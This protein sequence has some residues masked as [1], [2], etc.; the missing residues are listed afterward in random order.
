MSFWRQI[1]YWLTMA[2]A[3]CALLLAWRLWSEKLRGAF[4]WFFAYLVTDAGRTLVTVWLPPGTNGAAYLYIATEPVMWILGLMMVR[5]IFHHVLADHRGID[6]ASRR[7]VRYAAFAAAAV[8][9]ALLRMD[10]G[11]APGIAGVLRFTFVSGRVVLVTLVILLAV[12]VA[13]MAWF[14]VRISRNAA[15]LVTGY[16]VYFGS[17]GV[18]LL[19]R[20][21]A[22][23]SFNAVG[24]TAILCLAITC[25]VAGCVTLTQAHQVRDHEFAHAHDSEQ[26][27]RLLE[28]LARVNRKLEQS[29]RT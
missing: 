19:M 17:K 25:L 11:T 18:L 10:Y 20:N 8:S 6:S 1:N 24:G 16:A 2:S 21:I 4:P 5:E 13:F 29:A 23:D 22:G 15:A 26:A 27:E 12:G 28:Q 14:P 7:F 9:A 3:L